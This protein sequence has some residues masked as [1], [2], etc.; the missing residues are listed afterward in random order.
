[1][2][3]MKWNFLKIFH[4]I[5]QTFHNI[6]ISVKYVLFKVT[7]AKSFCS[8][9]VILIFCCGFF[10]FIF[11]VY[12]TRGQTN[13]INYAVL[14]RANAHNVDLNRNFPDQYE[15]TSNNRVQEKETLVCVGVFH[16]L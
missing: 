1:M 16:V 10:S 9:S 11:S 13:E 5:Q 8:L 6:P 14:G 2:F 12:R 4:L 3:Q 15:T 7:F